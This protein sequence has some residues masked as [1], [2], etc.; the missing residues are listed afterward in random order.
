MS[1]GDWRPA[2]GPHNSDLPV[3]KSYLPVLVFAGLGVTVG[4]AFA[5]LNRV[6]GPKRPKR[7]TAQAYASPSRTSAGSRRASHGFRFGVSFYMIAMLFILFDIEVVFLYPVG[8]L[9]QA[10]KS[11]FVLVEMVIFV[12]LLLVALVFVWREGRS[13][14]SRAGEPL[15]ARQLRARDLLRGDLEGEDLEQY[16]EE[17]APDDHLEKVLNWGAGQRD[18]PADLR[19][20]LLRDRA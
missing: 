4:G 16:V 7:P 13:I 11:V 5:M 3:L 6:I 12:A 1:G 19:P 20:R 9:V 15:R 17:T 10:T 18:L 2:D 8:V 14:G